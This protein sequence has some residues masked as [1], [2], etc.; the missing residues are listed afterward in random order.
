VWAQ[1]LALL[2]KELGPA[3]DSGGGGGGQQQGQQQGQLQGQLQGQG[4][5]VASIALVEVEWVEGE[6]PWVTCSSSGGAA[7]E[8]E[9]ER[10]QNH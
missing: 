7:L 9:G 1:G 5:G 2:H 8:Q 4:R 10:N 3:G 6:A